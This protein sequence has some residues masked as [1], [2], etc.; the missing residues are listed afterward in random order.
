MAFD[1]ICTEE[2]S[3]LLQNETEDRHE[4][5]VTIIDYFDLNGLE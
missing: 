3:G 4:I 1:S 2:E 5:I